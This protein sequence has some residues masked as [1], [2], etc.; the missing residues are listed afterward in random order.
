L[1]P[2]V[3]AVMLY[4]YIE[5]M[6]EKTATL[7]VN[8]ANCASCVYAIEHLGRKVQGVTD[9]K[10]DAAH[11]EIHVRYEGNPGS[12]ERI[13]EVVRRLGYEAKVRWESVR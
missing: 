7:D 3:A 5:D 13:S 2:A 8:G 12:L 6:S 1:I 4:L 10:V 9:V 11:Q